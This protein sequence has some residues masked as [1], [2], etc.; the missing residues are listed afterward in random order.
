MIEHHGLMKVEYLEIAD[1]ENL[2]PVTIWEQSGHERCFTAVQLGRV[3]LI[4]N[5]PIIKTP[6]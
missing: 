5:V 6:S 2:Q 3:R 1:G 4:D